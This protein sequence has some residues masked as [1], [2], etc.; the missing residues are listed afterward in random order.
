VECIFL[1]GCH[2]TIDHSGKFLAR[3]KIATS[4]GRSRAG[5]TG[6][7]QDEEKNCKSAN[8]LLLGLLF[9]VL[10]GL[11][12]FV[13]L[14]AR[15]AVEA[16][17]TL[18]VHSVRVELHLEHGVHDGLLFVHRHLQAPI[19]SVRN[20]NNFIRVYVS[21]TWA[22]RGFA[23]AEGE[24]LAAEGRTHS[25]TRTLF[26][27]VQRCKASDPFVFVGGVSRCCWSRVCNTQ[28]LLRW[29]LGRKS[30]KSA[31]SQ[32]GRVVGGG[33]CTPGSNTAVAAPLSAE[34]G[35]RAT[36]GGRS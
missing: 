10:E 11:V 20:R 5:V 8:L 32:A 36:F 12:L 16:R 21:L 4:A 24:N 9:G 17:R 23:T 35:T 27:R 26:A 33:S 6:S 19:K 7:R 22:A 3:Q 25:L 34:P 15:V 13:L 1:S 29:A 14:V 2:F 30:E 28:T 18:I 31:A